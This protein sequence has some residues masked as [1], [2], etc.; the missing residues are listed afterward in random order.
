MIE[1]GK[2]DA[3]ATGQPD[4][5]LDLRGVICPYN[6]VKTKLRLEVMG[7]GQI[8]SV[9]LGAGDLMWNVPHSVINEGHAIVSQNHMKGFYRMIIC[10]GEDE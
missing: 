8:T 2:D 9:L 4:V 10:R 3:K 7:Q 6:F 1:D 5:E